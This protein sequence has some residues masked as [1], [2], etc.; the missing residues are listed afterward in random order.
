MFIGQIADHGMPSRKTCFSWSNFRLIGVC[1]FHSDVISH[2]SGIP[3]AGDCDGS[4][5][6]PCLQMQC[7]S[8]ISF[9]SLLSGMLSSMIKF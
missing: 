4:V 2:Q 9:G 8:E 7:I 1:L 5:A 6:L 3:N